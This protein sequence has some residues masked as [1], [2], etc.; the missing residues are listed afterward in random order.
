MY[1]TLPRTPSPTF[2]SNGIQET[3]PLNPMKLY[4]DHQHNQF[5]APINTQYRNPIATTTS[6][7]EHSHQEDQ[8][9]SSSK[10]FVM[11]LISYRGSNLAFEFSSSALVS[12][13][14]P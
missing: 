14:P 4:L 5:D 11:L 7:F 2:P 1:E 8:V 12:Q 9:T 6:T 10:V 13:S 3:A